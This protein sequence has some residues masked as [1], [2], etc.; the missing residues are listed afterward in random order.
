MSDPASKMYWPT[1]PFAEDVDAT[2][3]QLA[4]PMPENSCSIVQAAPSYSTC[5]CAECINRV[6]ETSPFFLS[7]V[8]SLVGAPSSG[9]PGDASSGFTLLSSPAFSFAS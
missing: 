6:H 3:R 7:P 5:R 2:R 4:T 8:D 1:R 9:L